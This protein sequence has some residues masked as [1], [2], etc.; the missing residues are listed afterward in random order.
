MSL[1]STDAVVP[2][3][4]VVRTEASW[5]LGTV[6]SSPL[7]EV[8]LAE[9]LD[10]L[11]PSP[12]RGPATHTDAV[13]AGDL[14]APV[15]CWIGLVTPGGVAIESARGDR[16]LLDADD[17][18]LLDAVDPAATV[19]DLAATTGVTDAAPRLA[20]LL[21]A[22]RLRWGSPDDLVAARLSEPAPA[23]AAPIEDAP[24]PSVVT[25]DPGDGRIP[26]HAAWDEAL[27]PMLST[28]ILTAAARHWQDGALN[29]AYDIARPLSTGQVLAELTARSGPAV[30]LCSNYVWSLDINLD[31]ARQA[32]AHNPDLVVIHGGPS[33]PK[34]PAD[35]ERFL[36]ENGDV[37]DVLVRG[38]GELTLCLV[39]DALAPTLPRIDPDRLTEI[40]G[41][42][43]RHPD[44]GEVVRTGEPERLTDLNSFPSPY[45]SG[46]FDHVE[47]ASWTNAVAIETNRGC[48]Y[49]CTYCDWGSATLSRIRKFDLDRVLAEIEWA[50]T[51]TEQGIL[52]CDANFGIMSRDVDISE[53]MADIRRRTGR[54]TVLAVTPAKNTTKHMAKI[55]DACMSADIMLAMAI[56]PQSVD[57]DTLEAIDRANVST[58]TY[59]DLAAQ[60]RRR[61]QPL[62]GDLLLGL[63]GQTY[64]SYKS[65]LQF[66]VDHE[67]APRTWLLKALPNAPMNDP[68][69]K[70]RHQ[71]QIDETGVVGGTDRLTGDDLRAMHRLRNAEI[72]GVRQSTLRHIG[73]HLQWDHDVPVLEL[74]DHLVG[75]IGD[76]PTRFPLLTWLLT[77]FDL[78][79]TAPVGW[80]ALYAE[81][82]AYLAEEHDVDPTGSDV[83][84]AMK[85]QRHLMPSPGR[86][87]PDS[88]E[89]E[90]DFVAY[91]RDATVSLYTTGLASG[92]PRPLRDYGP[93]VFTVSGDP[94]DL[95]S[96]GLR[97]AGNSRNPVV[98]GDFL[99]GQIAANEL[100]SPLLT[101]LPMFSGPYS[102]IDGRSRARE[103]LG[104]IPEH[105]L[106]A[107]EVTTPPAR[108]RIPVNLAD[109][110]EAR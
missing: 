90:H 53:G 7:T 102:P 42:T 82:G 62:A 9:L 27:G 95:C 44:T 19:A 100:E 14:V 33:T 15:W 106:A 16:L 92:A 73:R 5:R 86:T 55:V 32:K 97:F 18:R 110:V 63:P 10:L 35:A 40:G 43:Y 89:L 22:G 91:Y 24:A 109:T 103:V 83:R 104:Q 105:L 52:F 46:E 45:L 51:H 49:G 68:A 81:L 70:A 29:A 54:P 12:A 25:P 64:A 94:L 66:M 20:R 74:L 79:A 3:R 48:P 60:L 69:Y 96:S 37:A 28:G 93:S 13:S 31:L 36:A 98:E 71:L 56:S 99:V 58:N 17:L 47:F 84:T 78:H 1:P 4:F 65:D 50:A 30:L 76:D 23:D 87:F 77:E 38:E 88:I 11:A 101:L 80:H 8:D 41:L 72:I 75:L 57:P 26:V 85:V 39:L 108:T 59:L 21:D 61:G 6:P 34:F 107:A 2:V 67:I